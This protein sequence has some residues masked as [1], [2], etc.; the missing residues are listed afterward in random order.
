MTER[1]RFEKW[2][3][4]NVNNFPFASEFE[5]NA[6]KKYADIVWQATTKAAAPEQNK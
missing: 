6:F 3:Y 1:E 2:F 4:N 5:R